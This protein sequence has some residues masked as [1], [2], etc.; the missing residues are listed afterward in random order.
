MFL[1]QFRQRYSTLDRF[2]AKLELV[3]QNSRYTCHQCTVGFIDISNNINIQHT[4]ITHGK[5]FTIHPSAQISLS[6]DP[7][8]LGTTIQRSIWSHNEWRQSTRNESNG[9][10]V[11]SF[12]IHQ[13]DIA[14]R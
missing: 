2:A 4:L 11:F 3:T 7:V 1:S 13:A 5:G 14:L 10:S 6:D 12:E 9:I 8:T